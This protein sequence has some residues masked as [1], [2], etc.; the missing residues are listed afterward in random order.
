MGKL[1]LWRRTMRFATG[2]L[3]LILLAFTS[4]ILVALIR[5]AIRWTIAR[6]AKRMRSVKSCTRGVPS[7]QTPR[8]KA[9]ATLSGFV[10]PVRHSMQKATTVIF[11]LLLAGC[12]RKAVEVRT[13]TVVQKDSVLIEVPR[14]TEL[15]IDNPCDSAGILRGFRFTDSTK[16]GVLSASNY[17]GGIR[18]QLRRDTVI[19]RISERDTVTIERVVKVGPAKRKNRM[20]FVWFGVALGL[21]LSI[22][23]FRL[24]RL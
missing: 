1:S 18:I 22:A 13:T 10:K 23:A 24:M 9:T 3:A 8:F 4:A 16:S 11:S 19:Q 17:R 14:Y 21:V 6:R 2:W 15:F 20:A 12:C 7:T 5:A